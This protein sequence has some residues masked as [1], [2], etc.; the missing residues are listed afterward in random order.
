MTPSRTVGDLTANAIGRDRLIVQHEGSTVSG[1][2]R[3]LEIDATTMTDASLCEPRRV[4][5]VDVRITIT[6]GSITVGP[7]HREH[8]CEVI[9]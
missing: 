8:A 9:A 7:L 6:I 2:L 3:D 5:T 4:V 1:V